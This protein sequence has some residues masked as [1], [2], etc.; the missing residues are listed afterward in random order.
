[1]IHLLLNTPPE[2]VVGDLSD[3]QLTAMV[4]AGVPLIDIRRQSEWADTGVIEGS[5]LLT[6]FDERSKYDLDAWLT[7]FDKV[8]D[9]NE[10]FIL[11]CRQG[12]RTRKLGR[13]LDGRP[14]FLQVNHLQLGISGWFQNGRPVSHPQSG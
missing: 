8:A 10:P 6:F 3:E 4:A 14:D 13:F 7:A 11:I 5:H 9:R 12:I 2:A 1:M